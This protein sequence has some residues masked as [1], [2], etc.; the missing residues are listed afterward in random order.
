LIGFIVAVFEGMFEE[1]GRF[2]PGS[3][4]WV[5]RDTFSL[6]I[7]DFMTTSLFIRLHSNE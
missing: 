6:M 7:D 3:T 2:N 1:E 5:W 4:K